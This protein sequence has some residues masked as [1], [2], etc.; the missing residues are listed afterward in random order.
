MRNHSVFISYAREDLA[1][2]VGVVVASIGEAIRRAAARRG[3]A[4]R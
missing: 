2:D 4:W 3:H 1:A